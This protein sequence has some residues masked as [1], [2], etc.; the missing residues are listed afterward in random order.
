M[1]ARYI[2]P[3]STRARYEILRSC[4]DELQRVGIIRQSQRPVLPYVELLRAQRP[5]DGQ[6][7]SCELEADASGTQPDDLELAQA[8]LECAKAV[9]GFSGRALRKLPF[10]AHALFAQV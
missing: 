9:E 8:L 1:A 6:E 3:P 4:V 7:A 10:Q 2:G 5:R